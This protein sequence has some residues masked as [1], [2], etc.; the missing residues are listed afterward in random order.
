MTASSILFVVNAGPTIGGGHVMRSL[1][2]AT[3]LEARGARCSFLA[4]PSVGTILESFAPE[5]AQWPAA[6]T[7]PRDLA[8]GAAGAAAFDAVVF[9]HYGLAE[10]DHKTIGKGRPA[11]A[12]DDLADRPLGAGM[13]V[14]SGPARRAQ[15]YDGL[16]ADDARL[17]LG[18]TFAPVRP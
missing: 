15:D 11:L 16:I 4:P 12:I 7:E 6:S 9:D 5:A 18:P 14:D 1:T 17:L 10:L 8:A 3:A 13:V 2:L